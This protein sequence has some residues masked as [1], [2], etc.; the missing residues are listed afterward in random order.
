MLVEDLDL[1][2]LHGHFNQVLGLGGVLFDVEAG[3]VR[4]LQ[5]FAALLIVGRWI[6]RRSGRSRPVFP[7][8]AGCG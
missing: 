8:W 4:V 1:G 2:V 5:G 3:N 6:P 7:V